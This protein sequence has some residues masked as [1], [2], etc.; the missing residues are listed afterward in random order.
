MQR[1]F[2]PKYV[3]YYGNGTGRDHQIIGNNGGLTS[4]FK[5]GMGHTG[6]QFN[7]YATSVSKRVSPSP[8][9]EATTFYYQ[10]DG[11]GRD[12]YVLQDNGG[13]R[14]EYDKYNKSSEAI[15]LSSLRSQKKSSVKYL[16]HPV[17]DR[18]DITTY[19]NWQSKQGLEQ[20]RANSKIQR[21][22]V[23]RLS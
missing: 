2:Y 10:S 8:S 23:M 16:K 6:V 12:S 22:V 15:F 7:R 1:T 4:Q 3:N 19:L 11:S 21:A 5:Y 13:L 17:Q 14:P 18:A 20:S 9:R